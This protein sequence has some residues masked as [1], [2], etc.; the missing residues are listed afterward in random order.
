MSLDTK[1]N[2]NGHSNRL[3]WAPIR[4]KWEIGEDIQ[5]FRGDGRLTVNSSGQ[6]TPMGLAVSSVS[7]H[8]GTC[9]VR[10]R[11]T[12]LFDGSEQAGGIVLGY[13]S[14]ERPYL[15]VRLGGAPYA[16]C[17]GQ[18]ADGNWRL[19]AAAGQADNLVQD[20][21]YL[22]QLKLTGQELSM[23]VDGVPV[24]NQVLSAPVEG[25]QVGLIAAGRNDISFTRFA[26]ASDRPKAFVVMQFS[27]PYNT[28]YREVIQKQA[29][30]AGFEVFRIIE[31]PGPGVIFED[32]Q[33]EIEQSSVVI[34]E[35]T[36]ANPNVYYEVGYAHA[37]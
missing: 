19:L 1:A 16:Y 36:P 4:G 25:R 7:M 34:A 18:Y 30:D 2:G 17:L 8:S 6:A 24:L 33:H 28:F 14:P 27:E 9:E 11:F 29:T 10:V 5:T 13:R 22:I 12:A 15:F 26:N 31:K 37:L 35:I 20:R 21:D 3:T 32:I 23:A